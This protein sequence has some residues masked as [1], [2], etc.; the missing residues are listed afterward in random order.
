[1]SV[2]AGTQQLGTHKYAAGNYD[3]NGISQLGESA[4]RIYSI[5]KLENFSM[6]PA[7]FVIISLFRGSISVV[8]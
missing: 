7:I 8:N 6:A 1:M 2:T 3:F 4:L 5:D